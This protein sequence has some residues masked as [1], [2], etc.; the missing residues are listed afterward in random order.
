MNIENVPHAQAGIGIK[1]KSGGTGIEINSGLV[2]LRANGSTAGP[3]SIFTGGIGLTA[4]SYTHLI[5][6]NKGA[7]K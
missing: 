3:G 2:A 7:L 4:V 5:P 1:V 6:F